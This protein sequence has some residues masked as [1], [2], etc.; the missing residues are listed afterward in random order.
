MHK[1]LV[2]NSEAKCGEARLAESQKGNQ[3]PIELATPVQKLS[4][5]SSI[6]TRFTPF[7]AGSLA[8]GSRQGIV[9]YVPKGKVKCWLC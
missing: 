4:T 2:P 7:L 6:F 5:V 9:L 1:G 3:P 8:V